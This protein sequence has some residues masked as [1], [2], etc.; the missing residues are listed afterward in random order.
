M[1]DIINIYTDGTCH[2]QLKTGGWAAIIFRNEDKI[3][4]LKEIVRE[5]THNRMEMMAVI[6]AI[7]F[8]NSTIAEKDHRLV[9][10]S[11]SQYVVNIRQRMEKLKVN[12]FLTKKGIPIQNVALVKRLIFYIENYNIEFKKVKAHQ[13]EQESPNYNREAD[14]IVRRML[15]EKVNSRRG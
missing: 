2:T 13:K 12:N 3:A 6:K 1:P 8:V 14:K 4:V 11:D 9:V 10:Y 15:R 5:T 7:E